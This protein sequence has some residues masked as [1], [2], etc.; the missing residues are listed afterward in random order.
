MAGLASLAA[1]NSRG[2]NEIAEVPGDEG[3]VRG[4]R[5]KERG[6]ACPLLR[7]GQAGLPA[8][9]A[10]CA[11]RTEAQHVRRVILPAVRAIEGPDDAV[12]S[13]RDRQFAPRRGGRNTPKPGRQA[14][15]PDGAA[16]V[17]GDRDEELPAAATV[18]IHRRLRTPSRSAARASGARR[19]SRRSG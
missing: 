6:A 2:Y 7:P 16:A 17:V 12:G 18:W 9:C 19:L 11:R 14:G 3:A 4:A 5:G 10:G 8:A 1:R 15:R 13:E